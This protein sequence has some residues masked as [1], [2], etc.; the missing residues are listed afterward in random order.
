M[1]TGIFKERNILM[2]LNTEIIVYTQICIWIP[3]KPTHFK[4]WLSKNLN[5]SNY[6][7]SLLQS[8]IN[9]THIK[10]INKAYLY[11]YIY[12]HIFVKV[13]IF[14]LWTFLVAQ[15]VKNLPALQEIWVWTMGWEDLLAKGMATHFSIFFLGNTMNR[16][17]WWA[18]IHGLQRFR[19]TEQP[20]FPTF[21][22]YMWGC[23]CCCCWI[24]SVV[25]DSVHSPP[26]SSVPGI[27]QA[28][29]LEWVAISYSNAG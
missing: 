24:A 20:T 27:L 2:I 11:I 12:I 17:A 15:K 25:S 10:Y 18:T 19:Q 21:I 3:I 28:R 6:L 29:I 8:T 14:F 26:G 22:L 9:R 4:H 23:C 16:G 5:F 1:L 13:H 7:K